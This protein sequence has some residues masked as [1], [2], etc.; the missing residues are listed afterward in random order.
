MRKLVLFL[1]LL[2][3]LTS[4]EYFI[5]PGI[6]VEPKLYMVAIGVGLWNAVVESPVRLAQ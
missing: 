5:S 4:C 6:Q 3:S 2:V 1:T